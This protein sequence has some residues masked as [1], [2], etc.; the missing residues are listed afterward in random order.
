MTCFWNGLLARLTV[1]EINKALKSNLYD[2]PDPKLFVKLLKNNATHTI[3][4]ECV[5]NDG[6]STKLTNKAL[7]ENLEWII[8]Y[9]VDKIHD[10]HDCSTGDPFLLLVSQ[11]FTIDIYHIYNSKYFIKYINSKNT[12]G[13]ILSLSSDKGHLW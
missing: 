2:K 7:E 10:G 4:V 6:T 13:R 11:L 1:E 12:Y 3:D 8:T 9:N 5:E